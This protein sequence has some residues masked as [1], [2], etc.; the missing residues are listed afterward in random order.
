MG[1]LLILP[2]F[3]LFAVFFAYSLIQAV[4]YS[5]LDWDGVGAAAVCGAGELRRT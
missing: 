1:Y 4:K 5:L 3:A 2:A